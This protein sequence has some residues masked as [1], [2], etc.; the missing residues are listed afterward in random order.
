MPAIV[1]RI[2]LFTLLGD[3]PDMKDIIDTNNDI[4]T[5]FSFGESVLECLD[6]EEDNDIEKRIDS[7]MESFYSRVQQ[8]SANMVGKTPAQKAREELIDLVHYISPMF[9]KTEWRKFFNDLP[10]DAVTTKAFEEIKENDLLVVMVCILVLIKSNLL[11]LRVLN[12]NKKQPRG[13]K[14][15]DT[16]IPGQGA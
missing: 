5:M 11:A 3:R 12:M 16:I 2:T 8:G 1:D 6:L 9:E 13:N 15:N 4:I 10:N 14:G 7:I